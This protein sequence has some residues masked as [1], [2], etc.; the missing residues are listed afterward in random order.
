LRDPF[1]PFSPDSVL[2]GDVKRIGIVLSAI[3]VVLAASRPASAQSPGRLGVAGTIEYARMTDDESFLGDG[4]GGA[5]SVRWRFTEATALEVEAGR[6][7][8]VRDLDLFAVAQD[9]QGRIQ[10]VPYTRRWEG[11]A[12]FVIASVAH[13]F[14]AGRARPVLWGGGGLMYHGGT[15][16][17]PLVAPEAPPG[18]T[19]QPLGLATEEGASSNALVADGGFGIDIRV[20]PRMT[21][22]PFAGLRLTSAEQVGPKY[23]FRTGVRVGFP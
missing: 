1:A 13:T 9:T 23:I 11:T 17:G 10:P 5:A 18:F 6:T 19:L 4:I 8:H 3:G 21:V 7:R 15:S 16:R 14:G 20:A 22:R 12:T 2:E